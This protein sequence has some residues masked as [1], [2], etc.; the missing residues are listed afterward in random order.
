MVPVAGV[1][2]PPPFPHGSYRAG[3][4][5]VCVAFAS[6]GRRWRGSAAQGVVLEGLPRAAEFVLVGTGAGEADEDAAHG[7][8]DVRADLEELEADGAAGG[9]GQCGAFERHAP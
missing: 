6:G 7:K 8:S 5:R 9:V 2:T 4:H 3:S 1:A